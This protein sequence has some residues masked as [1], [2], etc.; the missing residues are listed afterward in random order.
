MSDKLGK[1]I[2]K[3]LSGPNKPKTAICAPY[4][5][6][7]W[8]KLLTLKSPDKMNQTGNAGI[9]HPH[10]NESQYRIHI[11][12]IDQDQD[13]NIREE[14]NPNPIYGN[15]CAGYKI[16][17][18][19]KNQGLEHTASLD[20]IFLQIYMDVLPGISGVSKNQNLFLQ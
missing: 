20:T 16:I 14:S 8:E 13:S 1:T 15:S 2:P 19:N 7:Y 6:W 4:Q 11:L 9:L 12:S 17:I 18:N 10:Q 5:D 3:A